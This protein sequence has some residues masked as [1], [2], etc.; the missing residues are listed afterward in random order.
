MDQPLVSIQT[1]LNTEVLVKISV[2]SLCVDLALHLPVEVDTTVSVHES[3]AKLLFTLAKAVSSGTSLKTVD[4][5]LPSQPGSHG[6]SKLELLSEDGC[7]PS[8]SKTVHGCQAGC[9]VSV[10]TEMDVGVHSHAEDETLQCPLYGMPPICQENHPLFAQEH[11]VG[12]A[13]GDNN[14]VAHYH[15]VARGFQRPPGRRYHFTNSLEKRLGLPSFPVTGDEQV[16][17]PAWTRRGVSSAVVSPKPHRVEKHAPKYQIRQPSEGPS[18]RAYHF[19]GALQR[20]F[21]AP[22]RT[23]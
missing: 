16:A 7:C 23:A 21:G 13:G 19:T 1:G 20:R 2:A 15:C 12:T 3:A 5:M 18:G 8:W 9:D 6:H 4:S 22:N 14:G 17:S 11:L 10:Q